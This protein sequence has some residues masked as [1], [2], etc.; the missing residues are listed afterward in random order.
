MLDAFRVFDKDLN[1]TVST[2][3][4]RHI[5]TSMGEKYTEDEFRE[6]IQGF[7]N[8]GVIEYQA[9]AKK[10]LLPFLE[11]GDPADFIDKVS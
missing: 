2:N 4:F 1:G 6:L 5:M 10:M 3:E 7:D 8:N 11:H 9:L